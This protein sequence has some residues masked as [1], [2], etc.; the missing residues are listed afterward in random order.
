MTVTESDSVRVDPHA[1][2]GQLGLHDDLAAFCFYLHEDSVYEEEFDINGVATEDPV[3]K[4]ILHNTE[5][6]AISQLAQ[7]MLEDDKQSERLNAAK[8]IISRSSDCGLA[9]AILAREETKSEDQAE[10]YYRKAVKLLEQECA[11]HALILNNS[12]EQSAEIEPYVLEHEAYSLI[13]GELARLI[14]RRGKQEEAIDILLSFLKK[15]ADPEE[16]LMYLTIN[17]LTLLNKD[18]QALSLLQQEP[19]DL[20]PWYYSNALLTY[21][22]QGNNPTSRAAIEKA[23]AEDQAIARLLMSNNIEQPL[24]SHYCDNSQSHDFVIDVQSSWQQSEGAIK[25]LRLILKQAQF[26]SEF[27]D[28]EVDAI[29]NLENLENLDKSR[30]KLWQDNYEL[31]LTF[32]QRDNLKEAKRLARF[33]L[34]EAEKLGLRSQPFEKT[35][36][37]LFLLLEDTD[38]PAEDI[39]KALEKQRDFLAQQLSV[40]SKKL[41]ASYALMASHYARLEKHALAEELLKQTMDILEKA[42]A[43][44]DPDVSLYD[45]SRVLKILAVSLGGQKRYAEAESYL[46]RALK[47]EEQFLGQ[48]HPDLMD[49]LDSVLRCVH[50]SG[51]HEEESDLRVRIAS[52]DGLTE[53]CDHLASLDPDSPWYLSPCPAN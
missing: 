49:T 45:L 4:P 8:E 15:Y 48:E 17:W 13:V 33:A 40:K 16:R 35:L 2:C 42:L 25:W 19:C 23:M 50:H 22:A 18:E 46:R 41:A 52:L 10:V 14:W 36:S 39:L 34:R 31:A 3:N 6:Y 24:V 27:Y 20:A 11:K 44:D 30:F 9:W 47:L 51:R 1:S 7:R 29:E 53:Y 38:S 5:I 37:M 32:M 12:R 21:R 28:P 26:Y 43:E